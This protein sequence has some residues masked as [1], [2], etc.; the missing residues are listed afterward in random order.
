MKLWTV[1]QFETFR[2]ETCFE[3]IVQAETKDEAIVKA[4]E[5]GDLVV[6]EPGYSPW[7]VRAFE[8]LDHITPCV[9]VKGK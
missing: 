7:G 4:F 2:G 6:T 3:V 9:E 1:Q 5:P 8:K